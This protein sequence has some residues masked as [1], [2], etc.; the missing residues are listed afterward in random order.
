M[1]DYH[2][3]KIALYGKLS[4][5]NRKKV[6]PKNATMSVSKSPSSPAMLTT[7]VGP[8]GSCL[9]AAGS[10]TDTVDSQLFLL[11]Q[12]LLVADRSMPALL[13]RFPLQCAGE[14]NPGPVST[15]TLTNCLRLMQWNAN[16]ISGKLTELLTFLHSNNVNIAA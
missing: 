4:I 1:E 10:P 11:V 6:T 16:G 15:P 5:G 2:L 14:M 13:L 3:P 12:S 7:Y 8:N 9:F